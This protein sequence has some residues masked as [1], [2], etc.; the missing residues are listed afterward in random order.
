MDASLSELTRLITEVYPYTKT[1]GTE[2][3]FA[4][5]WP[6]PV[7]VESLWLSQQA[8]S[9]GKSATYSMKEIGR[10]TIGIKG[11]DDNATLL[12]NRFIIGD[13]IDVAINI[14]RSGSGDNGNHGSRSGRDDRGSKRRSSPASYDRRRYHDYR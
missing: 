6:K 7:A 13:Y 3:Y 4:V 12:S 10:T 9:S 14:A 5:V 2:F 11:E 1:P 8:N